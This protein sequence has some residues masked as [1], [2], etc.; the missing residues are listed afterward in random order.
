[1]GMKKPT[2]ER[3]V[4]TQKDSVAIITLNR[5]EK[6]NA[7]DDLMRIDLMGALDWAS[8]EDAIRAIVL[9]GRGKA[10]CAG[11]DIAAMR[12]RLDAPIGRVAMNGWKRQRRT[13]HA[14]TMLHGLAKPT[15]AAVNGPAA[16]LGADLALCCDFVIASEKAMFTMSYLLR[17]LI[18]D[19]GGMYFLPRRVGLA[20]A[21]ELIFSGRRVLAKEALSLGMIENIT[22]PEEL[23]DDAI[24]TAGRMTV[25]SPDSLALAKSIMDQSLEL[26]IEEVFALGSQAQAICYTTDEHRNAVTAFLDKSKK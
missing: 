8:Q 2:S 17:G 5:P 13:H 6:L 10:F 23:L 24:D 4:I 14:I 19:G 1:M 25:G 16:G 15:I 18:P 7:I 9:T 21:K 22:P 11:G 26:S 20:R 12:E 3:V